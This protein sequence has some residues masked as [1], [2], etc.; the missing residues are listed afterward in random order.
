[1]AVWLP[2]ETPTTCAR[3][4]SEMIQERDRIRVGREGRVRLAGLAEA[5]GV[6]A[7]HREVLGEG[8]N[9]SV[10]HPAVADPGMKQEHGRPTAGHV[11]R[12]PRAVHR[13]DAVLPHRSCHGVHLPHDIGPRF[14]SGMLLACLS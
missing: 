13:G 11:V 10:P 4:M 8:G 1:M 9:L 7:D 3:E 12:D 5:T 2:I 14:A 6:E